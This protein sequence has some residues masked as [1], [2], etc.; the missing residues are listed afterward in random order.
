MPI[1]NKRGTSTH[2][3]NE[4]DMSIED[5]DQDALNHMKVDKLFD[6]EDRSSGSTHRMSASASSNVGTLDFDEDPA[7]GYLEGSEDDLEDEDEDEDLEATFVT[8]EDELDNNN[9]VTPLESDA[10]DDDWDTPPP[11]A[12][13]ENS[14]ND[15]AEDEA[16]EEPEPEEPEEPEVAA[17]FDDLSPAADSMPLLDVDEVPDSDT[18]VAFA[19]LGAS[20]M[21]IKGPR[22][23]ATMTEPRAKLKDRSDVYMTDAFQQVTASQLQELGLRRGLKSMGFALASVKLAKDS[24]VQAQVQ[25]QT[26]KTTAAVRNLAATKHAVLKQCMAIAAVGIN[27]RQFAGIPNE[28][29]SSLEQELAVAGVKNGKR[30]V[31]RAFAAFGPAYA[32]S[33]IEMAAKL[34]EMP[35]ES[36]NGIVEALDMTSELEDTPAEELGSAEDEDSDDEE[37]MDAPVTASTR[38]KIKQGQYSAEASAILK[39]S[40]PLF[41]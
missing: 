27:R 8:S 25:L 15:I 37:F 18:E 38:P 26:K 10:M 22:I 14:E 28:L 20:L 17:E 36:R 19:T 33:I 23:I 12:Q 2:N 4:E 1:V 41:S 6:P 34:S 40:R 29:R 3:G 16:G 5:G 32:K 11:D 7:E 21:V 13:I 39:G 9:G 35:E 30:M 31:A 24:V